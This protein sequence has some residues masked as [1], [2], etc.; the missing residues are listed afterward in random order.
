MPHD[1]G[2]PLTVD[3]WWME[4]RDFPVERCLAVLDN[5]ERARAARFLHDRS[6]RDYVAAHVLAR[7]LL[8]VRG[9]GRPAGQVFRTDGNGKPHLVPAAGDRDLRFNLTHTDGLVAV[10]AAEGAE[11]GVDAEAIDRPRVDDDVAR[12]VFTAAETALLKGRDDVSR[13][14][15]FF[16]LWTLKE[17]VAKGLGTGLSTPLTAFQVLGE[18][19]RLE[20]LD[21]RPAMTEPWHLRIEAPTARHLLAL[22][23]ACGDRRVTVR[24]RI[25]DGR[26]LAADETAEARTA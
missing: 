14:Q 9:A 2:P 18:P 7:H 26:S 22:A 19:P 15:T 20:F 23:V 6:R 21:G 12:A 5:A 4:T 16:R 17:A 24:H 25:V 10:A 3:L 8:A 13:R 1:A 11:I